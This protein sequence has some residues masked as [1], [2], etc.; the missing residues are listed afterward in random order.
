MV[1]PRLVGSLE[2]VEDLEFQRRSWIVQRIAWAVMAA[3]VLAAAAGLFG[4]GPLSDAQANSADGSVRIDYARFARYQAPARL[5]IQTSGGRARDGVVRISLNR[6]YLDGITIK[7]VSPLPDHTETAPGGVVFVV[8]E[9]EPGAAVT[10]HIDYEPARVGRLQ[11][12]LA[13]GDAPGLRFG[14]FVYP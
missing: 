3:V 14:Q 11:G 7:Q 12:Y 6:E 10:V 1:A 9:A 4:S 13:A 5:K 2:I 8:R